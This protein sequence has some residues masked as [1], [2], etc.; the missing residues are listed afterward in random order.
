MTQLTRWTAMDFLI[1]WQPFRSIRLGAGSRAETIHLE[2]QVD[3][4]GAHGFGAA[5]IQV[6]GALRFRMTAKC[7]FHHGNRY[8][9]EE[10][11]VGEMARTM[12]H[13][14]GREWMDHTRR[15]AATRDGDSRRRSG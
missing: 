5:A 13:L 2:C 9:H 7:T 10:P 4:S 6:R 8:E 12:R 15:G 11:T 3:S 1:G 14:I